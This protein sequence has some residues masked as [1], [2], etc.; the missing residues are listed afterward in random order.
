MK[1]GDAGEAFFLFE[2]DQD[3]PEDL[4]TSPL[5]EATTQDSPQFS[6]ANVRPSE[7]STEAV[8]KEEPLV[9][10]ISTPSSFSHVLK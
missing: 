8:G 3:V 10:C 6:T 1:I 7:S 4:I 5:L 2:A 9:V